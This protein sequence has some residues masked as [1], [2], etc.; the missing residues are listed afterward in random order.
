MAG[1][2]RC[3]LTGEADSPGGVPVNKTFRPLVLIS[4]VTAIIC[5]S[6]RVAANPISRHHCVASEGKPQQQMVLFP[7]LAVCVGI[8][9]SYLL[10]LP[11]ARA[12]HGFLVLWGFD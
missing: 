1:C 10:L 7:L 5:A 9:N 3:D 12:C 2:L 4:I 6:L 8:E 11:F